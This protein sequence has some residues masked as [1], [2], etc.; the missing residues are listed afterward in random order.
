M[1]GRTGSINACLPN[2]S[3]LEALR[4]Q[5][6]STVA[7]G[8]G[9]RVRASVGRLLNQGGNNVTVTWSIIMSSHA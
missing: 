7:V 5:L 3:G 9:L 6:H 4:S 2:W 1:D 8:G